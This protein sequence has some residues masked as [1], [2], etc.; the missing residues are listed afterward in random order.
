MEICK[1]CGKQFKKITIMHVRTHGMSMEEY[2]AYDPFSSKINL[3]PQG[4]TEVTPEEREK[5]I[6]GEQE[7]DVN[8]PLKEFLDEFDMT[9]VELRQIAK[10]FVSGKPIDVKTAAENRGK[11]GERE[12]EEIANSTKSGEEVKTHRAETADTLLNKHGFE[13]LKCIGKK[14]GIPKHWVLRK[15]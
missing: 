10:K 11:I 13:V 12:A 1:V 6:W 3:E 2:E 14:G 7:R 15:L 9:E 8:R 4:N 5:R